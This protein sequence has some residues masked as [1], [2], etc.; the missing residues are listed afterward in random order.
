MVKVPVLQVS[1]GEAKSIAQFTQIEVKE[2][3]FQPRPSHP[4]AASHPFPGSPLARA[5]ATPSTQGRTSQHRVREERAKQKGGAFAKRSHGMVS[6][7]S[8]GL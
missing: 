2:R 3:S 1:N 6:G 4:G 5:T 7:H 8:R